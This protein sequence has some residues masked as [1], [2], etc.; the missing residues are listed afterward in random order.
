MS[1]PQPTSQSSPFLNRPS[2]GSGRSPQLSPRTT[3]PDVQPMEES[4]HDADTGSRSGSN[5]PK[6]KRNRHRKRRNR[7][8]SF[9]APEDSQPDAPPTVPEN[10]ALNVMVG[11]QGRPR[12]STPLY[13]LGGNLSNTSLESEALLDHRYVYTPRSFRL[14]RNCC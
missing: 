6:R 5:K 11:N 3:G 10:E 4:R 7:R 14:S 12:G 13:K 1:H 8:Q 2:L 9:L